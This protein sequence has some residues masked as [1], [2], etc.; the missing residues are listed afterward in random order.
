MGRVTAPS[1]KLLG[2]CSQG[3]LRGGRSILKERVVGTEAGT[4]RPLGVI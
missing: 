4:R 1:I 3:L 2:Q